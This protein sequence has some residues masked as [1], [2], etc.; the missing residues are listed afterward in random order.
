MNDTRRPRHVP[1]SETLRTFKEPM[2]MSR[3]L[4]QIREDLRRRQ[5]ADGAWGAREELPGSVEPTALA[6]LALSYSRQ[7]A[8]R[9]ASARARA[10]LHALQR[11]DGSWP[12]SE[13]V[14]GSSWMT[15]LA[16]IALW[17]GD[18]SEP[19]AVSGIRW[20]LSQKGET[21]PWHVRLLAFF[22]GQDPPVEMDLALEGWPW[23]E[24]TSSWV[25]PTSWALL[26][27][28]IVDTSAVREKAEGRIGEGERMLLDRTCHGGGWNYG[29]TRVLGE[30]LEPYPDTTALALM[31]LQ[32]ARQV[33][34][35]SAITRSVE[36][37]ERMLQRNDSVLSLSL[38]VLAL[39]LHGRDVERLRARLLERYRAGRLDPDTR[40]LT[41]A[42][43]ALDRSARPF[44]SAPA[45]EKTSTA[46]AGVGE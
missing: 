36:S 9:Y 33:D 11:S 29:N 42:A 44:E 3:G 8:D 39:Q 30:E 32:G 18:S 2:R 20:L 21:P 23:V 28:K 31:A 25:E 27:L 43:L 13:E 4:E 38:S 16:V 45:R 6:T 19:A 41:L 46:A 17:D 34:V 14:Q 15:S 5:R 40:S 26:A 1:I 24:G 35:G 22:R 10:W 37:L 12:H 7:Q